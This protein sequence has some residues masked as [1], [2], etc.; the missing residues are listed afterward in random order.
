M[1]IGVI[2]HGSPDY[3][4]DIV[5]D[6]LVRLM[7]RQ[8][9]SIDYNVRFGPGGSGAYQHLCQGIQG[10]EPF[11]IHDAEVLV[12][13]IRSLDAAR[14]WK[15]RT[16]KKKIAIID[17]E[18]LAGINAAGSEMAKVYFKREYFH[19][20][21]YPANVRPLPFAA[22]PE[23]HPKQQSPG[24]RGVFYSGHANHPFRSEIV[25]V[26]SSMGYSPAPNQ[27]KKD[28]NLSIASAVV[29][30]SIRGMGWDT[31]R[32]WEVPYFGAALLA[33]RPAQVIP[34]NFE[35]SKEAVF[36]DSAQDFRKK[37]GELM[38]SPENTME[39]AAAG[40]RALVHRHL[41][42]NRARTVLENMT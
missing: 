13:S 42:T 23:E 1:K 5:T 37:L 24:R 27:D 21:P 40:H 19:F 35:E 12:A 22:I 7:G 34:A 2:S 6:G 33:Q 32:Y 36:Y 15:A 9:L 30:V 17:G 39:I 18:D 14:K 16:G 31:Y 11:D 28:Y 29:G 10:P 20:T 3:L 8:T 41:S 4:M 25:A 38:A 26:L